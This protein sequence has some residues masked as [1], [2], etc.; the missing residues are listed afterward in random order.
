LLKGD[1]KIIVLYAMK[2][3]IDK[4]SFYKKHLE[5][6]KLVLLDV[7]NKTTT[8]VIDAITQR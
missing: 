7:Q 2:E 8:D 3:I 4:S 1:V 5:E 6:G